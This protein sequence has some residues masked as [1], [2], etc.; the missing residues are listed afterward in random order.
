M[1]GS[2]A[3]LLSGGVTGLIGSVVTN[4]AD[5]FDDKRK[6]NHELAMRELDIQE[7]DK[8][9]EHRKDVQAIETQGETQ[10]A[11]YKHDSR[12][13]SKGLKIESIWLKIPLVL[14]DFIRGCVRPLLTLFLVYLVWDTRQEIEMV[15]DQ[16]GLQNLDPEQA[17][18]MYSMTIEMI[19][20]LASTAVGWWF[21]TS[22]KRKRKN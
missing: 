12:A 13:Y 22:P 14:N 9:Y 7:M 2:L 8:E 1:L 5:Y 6:N 4:V 18:T 10:T 3:S 19:L 11:S 16:A 21:G 15:I 17:L 20:F